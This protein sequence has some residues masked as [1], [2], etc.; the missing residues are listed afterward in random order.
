MYS[1]SESEDDYIPDIGDVNMLE[2][3]GLGSGFLDEGQFD[4]YLS[5]SSVSDSDEEYTIPYKRRAP[6]PAATRGEG[7]RG[8]GRRGRGGSTV[9]S[10]PSH[11]K[12]TPSST[13]DIAKIVGYI[14]PPSTLQPP[15]LSS[16][17]EGISQTT[18]K[19]DLPTLIKAS[20]DGDPTKKVERVPSITVGSNSVVKSL[21]ST[22]IQ[23]P[24]G[25]I[26]P[27]TQQVDRIKGNRQL[28]RQPPPLVKKEENSAQQ[29]IKSISL[30]PNSPSKV[31]HPQIVIPCS[32]GDTTQ[33][34]TST[35][36]THEQ[37]LATVLTPAF[38]VSG[39]PTPP[40]TTAPVKRRPGRPRKDQV[41]PQAKKT[42]RTV[43]LSANKPNQRSQPS[44][45]SKNPASS[46][47]KSIKLT[48]YKFQSQQPAQTQGVILSQQSQHAAT[49]PTAQQYQPL[50]LSPGGSGI[51]G[52]LV[53]PLQIIPAA[54]QANAPVQVQTYS[55]VPQGGLF[56][57]QGATPQVQEQP[58]YVTKDGQLYQLIHPRTLEDVSDSSKK[59]SVIMQPQG[60]TG[61]TYVQGDIG[62]FHCVTQ[63]DGLPPSTNQRNTER[64]DELRK[65]F[66]KIRRKVAT[67]QLD[68]PVP[69]KPG[70]MNI[71]MKGC[72]GSTSGLSCDGGDEL[73]DVD[74][75][76]DVNDKSVSDRSCDV[77]DRSC[78]VDDRTVGDG[79]SLA[80]QKMSDKLLSYFQKERTHR[81]AQRISNVAAIKPKRKE[82]TLLSHPPTESNQNDRTPRSDPPNNHSR[83]DHVTTLRNTNTNT[84]NNSNERGDSATTSGRGHTGNKIRLGKHAASLEE[85]E[86]EIEGREAKK[87]GR[88][89]EGNTAPSGK[90]VCSKPTPAMKRGRGRRGRGRGRHQTTVEEVSEVGNY[91]GEEETCPKMSVSGYDKKQ[92]EPALKSMDSLKL[93]SPVQ[94]KTPPPTKDEHSQKKGR[95]R[96]C[97]YKGQMY[98]CNLCESAY[99]TKAGLTAHMSSNHH[100]PLAVSLA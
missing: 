61:T 68:G 63:L 7:G 17:Y 69:K 20:L 97:E 19:P 75:T 49:S 33:R 26:M 10:D 76:C 88:G 47:L 82:V 3:R 39:E 85:E 23:P 65:R 43:Q 74:D 100:P 77:D 44:R 9:K 21:T 13:D 62:S 57:L 64:K 42:A 84:N 94:E 86:D 50:I 5:A 11:N 41:N 79:V 56:Y 93:V 81:T 22:H 54:P 34:S 8:Y 59:V 38:A 96:K 55:T 89:N 70:K 98:S 78:D 72:V 95:P 45:G 58:T 48:Q 25:L 40:L 73:C 53:T 91:S 16:N 36:N 92:T 18:A 35:A 37:P 67:Q 32:D 52:N 27:S 15:P 6:K 30:L 14:P 46:P 80:E 24:P 60:G 66:Q 29:P 2:K 83:S 87:V 71:R 31:Y 28:K 99:T 51:H 1:D 4:G 12:N 90:R